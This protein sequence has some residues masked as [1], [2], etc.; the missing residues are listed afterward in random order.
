MRNV[1][2]AMDARHGFTVH[3]LQWRLEIFADIE[4]GTFY[5][6]DRALDSQRSSAF[7]IY[8]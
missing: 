1:S 6:A 5:R 2:A 7:N 8:L 3:V 4:Q